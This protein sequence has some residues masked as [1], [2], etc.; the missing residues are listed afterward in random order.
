MTRPG[1]A[2][3]V[4][5]TVVV[6]TWQGAHL[7]RSCLDSLRLQ[8]LAHDLLVVDNAS[9]DKTRELLREQYPEARTLLLE[10][11]TGFAGG[12][13]A[14]LSLIQ[15]R[16]FAVLNNDAQADA[17]WLRDCCSCLDDNPHVAAISPLMVLKDRP[18]TVN[19]AGVVLERSGYGS[20]RG[21]GE[22]DNDR[23]AQPANVFG[24][25]GGAG[26]FR[27]LAVKAVGGI[28]PDYFM[29]YED[30]DLSW[31]LRL[32]GWQVRYCPTATVRHRHAA[33]SDV[34]SSGFAFYNERNRLVTL[35]RCAPPG[36]VGRAMAR[37]LLT[38]A[39]LSVK[40]ATRS[41]PPQAVFDPRLRL[42]AFG[43]AVRTARRSFQARS[44]STAAQ[45]RTVLREWAGVE[46]K[47]VDQ[48]SR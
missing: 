22:P 18:S 2:T 44:L 46:S 17:G 35:M 40:T 7:L 31:R 47:P 9:T 36:F 14:A 20:D 11:N 3:S 1:T 42:R 8:D 29:Y 24:A 21:L 39:S 43:S 13:A 41:R 19:N 10:R 28:D 48:T 30:T 4:D 33:S 27:T 32:A 5:V 16:Y 25:S 15:T 37:H 6:V 45:R 34:Q 26:V 12:L 23:F 38:T